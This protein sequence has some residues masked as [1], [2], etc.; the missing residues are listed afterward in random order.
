[1]DICISVRSIHKI[2]NTVKQRFCFFYFYRERN[3]KK[4]RQGVAYTQFDYMVFN[5]GNFATSLAL[6]QNG[7]TSEN[8][9]P[10]FPKSRLQLIISITN[11]CVY[12]R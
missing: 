3:K 4:S 2:K 10:G 8:R 6:H 12:F 7:S 1:M 11:Q 5:Q 9:S